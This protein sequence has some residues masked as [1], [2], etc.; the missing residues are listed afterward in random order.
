[1]F[2]RL[3]STGISFKE[4][5]AA[6]FVFK[7][8]VYMKMRIP[9]ILS[10]LRNMFLYLVLRRKIPACI[11]RLLSIG[12]KKSEIEIIKN[13]TIK[14][15]VGVEVTPFKYAAPGCLCISVDFEMAWGARV[16]EPRLAEAYGK[17]SRDNLRLII[18][19]FEEYD[20]PV[21][22]A[23]VGR[24]FLDECYNETKTGSGHSNI[25]NN[26]INR[27]FYPHLWALKPHAFY[28][29]HQLWHAKDLIELIL[30]SRVKHEIG[31]HSFSHISFQSCDRRQALAEL[32]QCRQLMRDYGIPMKSMV[33]PQNLIG[34]LELLPRVGIIAFRGGDKGRIQY[35]ISPIDGLWD[36]HGSMQLAGRAREQ[37]LVDAFADLTLSAIKNR[38]VMH[39]WFHL[40]DV[41]RKMVKETLRPILS[42]AAALRREGALWIA[43]MEEIA[44]YCELRKSC[45]VGVAADIRKN[46]LK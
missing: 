15:A 5:R 30:R 20:I 33:F 25:C 39:L 11:I 13:Q 7:N 2:S 45:S 9:R 41:D 12:H 26:R 3:R 42:K 8:S 19:A 46:I 18:E 24:L 16:F 21:T 43:T 14:T 36:I 22:W 27:L 6:P 29:K 4:D 28:K 35:P 31:T 23:I 44:N 37:C 40:F 34:F 1:M 17:L 32:L 38:A 10:F